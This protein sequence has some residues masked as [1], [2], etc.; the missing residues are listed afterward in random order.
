M[1]AL[2]WHYQAALVVDHPWVEGEPLLALRVR[3]VHM[4]AVAVGLI[5]A[6]LETMVLLVSS[7]LS[8]KE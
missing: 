5:K 8:I 7:L 4:V 1:V 2:V 3:E 6:A